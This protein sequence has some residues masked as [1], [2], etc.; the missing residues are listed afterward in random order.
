MN[1]GSYVSPSRLTVRSFAE[2][3]WL[4]SVEAAVAGGNLRP[5]SAAQRRILATRHVVPRIGHIQLR[6]LTAPM[7]NALYGELLANGRLCANNKEAGSALSTTTVRAVHLVIHR[8]LADAERWGRVPNNV[9]AKASP[10]RPRNVEMKTW[11]REE[12]AL[13]TKATATSQFAALW[14]LL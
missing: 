3:E 7:L 12:L 14:R 6:D 4:P 5:S 8:M 9:A 2:N 11:G 10:P 1:A 13:F